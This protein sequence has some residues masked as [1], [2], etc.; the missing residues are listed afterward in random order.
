MTL[1]SEEELVSEFNN[2][3]ADR[4]YPEGRQGNDGSAGNTLEDLLGVEE[5]NLRLPDWGDIELKTKRI[6]SQSLITL[7]HREPQ[8]NASVPKLL[9]SLGWKHQKAGTDYPADE[10]S[11]RSTTRAN[12]YSDRGF[13]ILFKDNE[14]HFEFQPDEVN[15]EAADRT[16]IYPTYG[17]WLADV[18]KRKSPNYAEVFPI[19]WTKNYVQAEIR[20]KL[21][22]TLFC[23][24]KSK[25][26]GGVKHFNYVSATLFKGFKESKIDTLFSNKSLYVDFDARTHHNHGTK[27]RVD[28]SAIHELFDKV[29]VIKSR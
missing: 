27:F 1:F 8:P 7:L 9:S 6:E 20:N 21:D 2:E 14:I 15:C 3:I 4:W 17:D 26:I 5:N 29:K 12:D 16:K 19:Y 23:L 28:I 25:V 24:V 13:A 22:N 10:M 11:F 18:K